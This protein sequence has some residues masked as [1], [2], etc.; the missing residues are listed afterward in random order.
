[1]HELMIRHKALNSVYGLGRI[2]LGHCGHLPYAYLVTRFRAEE[3]EVEI[4]M[5]G[6]FD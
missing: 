6:Y 3:V 1:M 2:S 5:T 4:V